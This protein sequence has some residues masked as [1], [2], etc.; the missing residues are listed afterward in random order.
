[1]P[2]KY[3]AVTFRNGDIYHSNIAIA[4]DEAAV[5][6]HYG[7][8]DWFLIREASDPEIEA[9]ALKHMPFVQC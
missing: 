5:K 1:M 4:V 8:Y 2:R 6:A 9:A 3:Y 7:K